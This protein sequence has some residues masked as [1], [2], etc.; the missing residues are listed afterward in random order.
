[1]SLPSWL[2]KRLG[3]A[4]IVLI[5]LS[6]VIFC[7][8]RILPGDPARIALG[9]RVDEAAIQA[10]RKQMNL[11]KPLITQYFLWMKGLLTGDLGISLLSR[12]PVVTDIK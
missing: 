3:E 4:V 12:R 7:I 2:A 9:P 1:M 10:L 6:I 5:G 8:T 11:D